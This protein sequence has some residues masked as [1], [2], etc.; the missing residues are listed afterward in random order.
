MQIGIC[1]LL[2]TL[3]TYWAEVVWQYYQYVNSFLSL[4]SASRDRFRGL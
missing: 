1:P 4:Q 2:N 3:E